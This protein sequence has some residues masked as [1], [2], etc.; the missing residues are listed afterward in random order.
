MN[1][2]VLTLFCQKYKFTVGD[3]VSVHYEVTAKEPLKRLREYLSIF[4]K[5]NS[6]YSLLQ[7]NSL[8]DLKKLVAD[9]KNEFGYLR[10]GPMDFLCMRNEIL[11][12]TLRNVNSYYKD[13]ENFKKILAM[14]LPFSFHGVQQ[15]HG[16]LKILLNIMLS[17]LLFAN[18]TGRLI[19]F[20]ARSFTATSHGPY[21]VL[22][23]TDASFLFLP[24]KDIAYPFHMMLAFLVPT[25]N[26]RQEIEKHLG[27]AVEQELIKLDEKEAIRNKILTYEELA[28]IPQEATRSIHAFKQCME[29]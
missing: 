20:H 15:A 9:Y 6:T 21:F 13:D 18:W 7:L 4:W 12:P 5:A 10:R 3:V 19:D 17:S 8:P 24:P 26:E 25:E 28:N 29:R 23:D 22:V 1:S 27:K 11:F 14:N 2:Q 16:G